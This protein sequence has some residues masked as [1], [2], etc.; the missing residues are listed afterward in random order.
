MNIDLGSLYKNQKG[1][2]RYFPRVVLENERFYIPGFSLPKIRKPST[3]RL[4]LYRY[5]KVFSRFM[6][7]RGLKKEESEIVWKK[8]RDKIRKSDGNVKTAE[9]KERSRFYELRYHYSHRPGILRNLKRPGR[10]YRKDKQREKLRTLYKPALKIKSE[11][12]TGFI[13]L[14]KINNPY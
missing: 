13:K 10:R 7:H 2:I 4:R 5:K 8:F 12:G 9:G 1:T 11:K 3:F 14:P 6:E